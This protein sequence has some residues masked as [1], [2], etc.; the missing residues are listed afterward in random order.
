MNTEPLMRYQPMTPAPLG[1]LAELVRGA[2]QGDPS[3]LIRRLLPLPLAGPDDLSYLEDVKR[4]PEAEK[5]KAGA[6]LVPPGLA[7]PGKILVEVLRPKLAFTRLL[8]H[9]HPVE[10]VVPGVHPSAAV[11][12]GALLGEGVTL[13]PH[14]VVEA[15]TAIGARTVVMA[16]GV[17]QEGARIGAGCLIHPNVLIGHHVIVGD[18]VI[19]HGGAVIGADGFGYV[20][21]E[22]GHHVKIP[23][24]GSVV[25][26]D[27]VEI[28]AN[29]TIDRATY[30]ET[31]I[32]RGTKID[33]LVQVAHNVTI[34]EHSILAAQVGVA[35]SC[36]IGA[37]VIMGGQSGIADHKSIGDGSI[38]GAQGGA[39]GDIPPK[40][41]YSGYPARPHREQMRLLAALQQLPEMLK[42]VKELE[43]ARE[44]FRDDKDQGIS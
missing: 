5:S 36:A 41:F 20:A 9:C 23:Q 25:V 2:V 4:A 7:I 42:R 43:R 26:E 15:G 27:D 12:P 30:G 1:R 35:G 14:V 37:H 22:S 13:G 44:W 31:R 3:F 10:P 28:G 19:V 11:D 24:L 38:L 17:V 29:A 34:G 6:L 21:D 16:G 33:N 39:I 32:G 40:S 18:R 8:R